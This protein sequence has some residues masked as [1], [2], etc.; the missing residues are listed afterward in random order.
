MK[1]IQFDWDKNKAESNM[2]KHDISFSEAT[3]VFDDDAARLIFD[4]DHSVKEDSFLLLGIS[5]T[6]KILVVVHCYKD[7]ESIIRIISARKATK[8]EAKQ[9][10]EF[11]P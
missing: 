4:P 10:K 8:L 11:I 3:T 5:C 1:D 2:L 6:L 7:E 9:Y